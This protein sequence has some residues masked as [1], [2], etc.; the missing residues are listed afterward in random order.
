[1][2]PLRRLSLTECVTLP[3]GRRMTFTPMST[4]FGESSRESS[5]CSQQQIQKEPAKSRSRDENRSVW[6]TFLKA[7]EW[8]RVVRQGFELFKSTTSMIFKNRL[9]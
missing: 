2:I 8:T 6:K 4:P 1:M 7:E 9:E 3:S 5:D